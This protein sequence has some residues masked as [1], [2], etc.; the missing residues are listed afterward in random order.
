MGRP[1]SWTRSD[2]SSQPRDETF[3][4]AASR[5]IWQLGHGAAGRK[6]GSGPVSDKPVYQ[7]LSRLDADRVD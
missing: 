1:E 5:P 6:A 4:S 7:D 2:G 3:G